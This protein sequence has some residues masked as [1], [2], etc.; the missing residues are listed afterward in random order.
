MNILRKTRF[1]IEPVGDRHYELCDV[2]RCL[3]NL[4][5]KGTWEFEA[6]PP[7][8]ID[9]RSGGPIVD[10]FVDQMGKNA[11]IRYAYLMHD[12]MYTRE[13]GRNTHTFSRE[14]ADLVLREIL[15]SAGMSK[16]KAY[17]VWAA[18]RMFGKSSYEKDDEYTNR[19][20]MCFNIRKVS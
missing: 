10:L 15:I 5:D 7:A 6:R 14:F 9:F 3:A 16:F 2:A 8:I 19:N 1:T 18:V 12:M 4:G 17:T 13:C 11:D 20:T